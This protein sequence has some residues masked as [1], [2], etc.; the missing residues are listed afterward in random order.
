MA[1]DPAAENADASAAASNEPAA[2]RGQPADLR[3]QLADERARY[4][5]L[6][7]ST[8]AG[9]LTT[10]ADGVILEVNPAAAA[11]LGR[12]RHSLLRQPVHGLVSPTGETSLRK[13]LR[14]VR[15][16]GRARRFDLL[17]ATGEESSAIVSAHVALGS[18]PVDRHRLR[19]TLVDVTEDRQRERREDAR[20][21]FVV[22]AAH[23]LR[24]P[25]AGITAAIQVLQSGAKEDPGDRD[26]FLGHI[27]RQSDRLV[28]LSSALL[29]LARAETQ[30]E[31]PP[32]ELIPLAPILVAVAARAR[33]TPG[34]R[35]TVSCPAELAALANDA[36]TEQALSTLVDNAAQYTTA[37]SIVLAAATESGGVAVTVTDT[38]S[39]ISPDVRPRVFD[40]F[41]RGT[42]TGEG[43]GLGLSIA[44]AAVENMGGTLE[45]DSMRG[46][47][48]VA[49]MTLP[50]A[51]LV[52][53]K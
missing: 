2:V 24:T 11:L 4:A 47:G 39:G 51:R 12:G 45:L 17:L 9:L 34:V 18:Q 32:P 43:F 37:G 42:D 14:A 21:D 49:R 46:E 25:L 22:N 5:S 52:S 26:R 48:T 10:D 7:D 13:E 33:T 15:D 20:R 23:E 38:G 50:A 16:D 3:R 19:W 31:A 30:T 35:V 44:R 6:F 28:R 29:T 1:D 40:R 41:F 27:A 8:A 53:P 36:L